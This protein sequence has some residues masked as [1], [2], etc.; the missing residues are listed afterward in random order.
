MKIVRGTDPIQSAAM[1]ILVYGG[2]YTGKTSLGFTANK[3]ILLDLDNGKH[4]SRFRRDAVEVASWTDLEE[5]LKADLLLQGYD[6]VVIDTVGRLIELAASG[7]STAPNSRLSQRDFGEIKIR[8]DGFLRRLRTLG[9][10]LVLLAHERR[11][12]P[13]NTDQVFIRPDI[14]GSNLQEILRIADAVGYVSVNKGSRSLD[15]NPN[16]FR[17]GKNPANLKTASIP[18][19]EN[20]PRFLAD[21]IGQ[22]KAGLGGL[23]VENVGMRAFLDFQADVEAGDSPETLGALLEQVAGLPETMRSRAKK[24]LWSRAQSLGLVFENNRF[25]AQQIAES[26]TAKVG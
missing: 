4:R 17:T 22:I 21:I 8:F 1:C 9:K 20:Q 25:I 2:P 15:F 19:F 10:D 18:N 7:I 12:K 26:E 11:E 16:E 6:C 5:F 13:N 3:P 24:T 23:S 14:L